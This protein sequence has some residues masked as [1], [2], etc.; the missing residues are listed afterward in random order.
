MQYII[1]LT[2]VGS[3]DDAERIVMSALKSRLA[4]CAQIY[5]PISSMFWWQGQIEED[6]EWACLFKTK[7]SLYKD[8]EELIK[9]EHPYEVPE[10]V[11]IPILMGFEPYL[12]WVDEETRRKA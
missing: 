6:E 7:E 11:A 12:K 8:L 4:A 1:V 3:R 9:R 10:I 2:T 5:G